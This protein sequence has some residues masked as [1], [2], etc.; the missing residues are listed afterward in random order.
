MNA[1][2]FRRQSFC[3]ALALA[4][5]VGPLANAQDTTTGPDTPGVDPTTDPLKPSTAQDLNPTSSWAALLATAKAAEEGDADLASA[6]D[7][8]LTIV[9]IFD[10]LRPVAA[11]AL[12]RYALVEGNR[13]NGT[14]SQS[15]HTHLIRIFPDF[16]DYVT[17]SIEALNTSAVKPDGS[18]AD[19]WA[20][21]TPKPTVS[22]ELMRRDGITPATPSDEASAT[23]QAY[24]MSPELMARYGLLPTPATP[25]SSTRTRPSLPRDVRLAG[26]HDL[27]TELVTESARTAADLRKARLELQR[28]EGLRP[29]D[30]PPNLVSD[31]RLR[32]LLVGVG[33]GLQPGFGQEQTD[34]L[35][36]QRQVRITEYFEMTYKP[37]LVRTVKI[38]SR[39]L[40][41][42]RQE[43]TEIDMEISKLRPKF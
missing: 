27:R 39:E 40:D 15:A 23:P 8:Y 4:C 25:P 1:R 19:A 5:A 29:M 32:T 22:P 36:E 14:E 18:N 17:K 7:Q 33:D 11:E 9:R 34:T 6:S 16:P 41:D 30:I 21:P 37:R 42:L 13:Q 38:L 35:I 43:T 28:V 12:Y 26:L 3:L 2:S 20:G 10:A 24:K 31:E